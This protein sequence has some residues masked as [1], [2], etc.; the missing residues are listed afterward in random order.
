MPFGSVASRVAL[1]KTHETFDIFEIRFRKITGD[2][3]DTGAAKEKNNNSPYP[4]WFNLPYHDQILRK[5]KKSACT[6]ELPE[7]LPFVADQC[8]LPAHIARSKN[9]PH[10][11]RAKTVNIDACK[12]WYA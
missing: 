3:G 7:S 5:G 6:R 12:N 8:L 9:A 4:P 1:T 11:L 2:T 10:L